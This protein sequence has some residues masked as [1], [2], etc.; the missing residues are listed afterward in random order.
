[1]ALRSQN[2]KNYN[3]SPSGKKLASG[4]NRDYHSAENGR[5]L[6][7]TPAGTTV[8]PGNGYRYHVYF[9]PA[10]IVIA[11]GPVTIDYLVVAGGGA[12]GGHWSPTP[13]TGSPGSGGG[14]SGGML[15]GSTT[16]DSGPYP[17]SV[18]PG[19]TGGQFQGGTGGGSRLG[20]IVTTGGGG[21]GSGFSVSSPDGVGPPNFWCQGRPGGSGGGGGSAPFPLGYPSTYYTGGLGNTPQ[22]TPS[23]GNPGGDSSGGNPRGAGGGGAGGSGS[24]SPGGG[25]AGIGRDDG[26]FAAPLIAPAIPAPLRPTWITAVGSN[27][28]YASGGRGNQGISPQGFLSGGGGAGGGNPG[29]DYTGGGGAGYGPRPGP[30]GG[31]PGGNGGSGLVV[32]RYLI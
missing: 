6:S 1:M 26:K 19:G 21:G 31:F 27:G 30:H 4:K 3:P 12:G 16:L 15:N 9:S 5:V 14:G 32:F 11:N 2:S 10:N 8:E 28:T 24:P 22:T 20:S 29:H 13:A 17:I 7:I 25:T 18:G 23:Q